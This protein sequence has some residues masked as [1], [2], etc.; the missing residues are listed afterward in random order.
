MPLSLQENGSQKDSLA[1]SLAAILLSDSNIDISADNLQSVLSAASVK[2]PAYLPP[3]YA[4]YIEKSG[5][6]SRFF[7]GPSAGGGGGGLLTKFSAV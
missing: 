4:T 7:S 2:V 6:I 1:I 5:G 3:L